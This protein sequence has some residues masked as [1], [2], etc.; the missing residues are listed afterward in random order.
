MSDLP[1]GW[2]LETLNNLGQEGWEMLQFEALPLSGAF[3]GDV[4]GYMY[5]TFYKRPVP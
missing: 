3:S 4:E 1:P 5:I 2:Y